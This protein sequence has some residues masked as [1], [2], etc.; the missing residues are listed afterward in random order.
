MSRKRCILTNNSCQCVNVWM[1]GCMHIPG[2]SCCACFETCRVV[3]WWAVKKSQCRTLI[4]YFIY[5]RDFLLRKQELIWVNIIWKYMKGSF[6]ISETSIFVYLLKFFFNV[7]SC[8]YQLYW[9]LAVL[10]R[11]CTSKYFYFPKILCTQRNIN[12]TVWFIFIGGNLQ[13]G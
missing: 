4:F 7:H 10:I 12:Q 3:L 13:F 2:H 9:C 8:K 5:Q 6:V 1:L 11:Y